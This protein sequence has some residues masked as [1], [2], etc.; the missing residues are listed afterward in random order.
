MQLGLK[1]F[2]GGYSLPERYRAISVRDAR[3]ADQLA[4]DMIGLMEVEIDISDSIML[5]SEDVIDI[6]ELQ[7][8]IQ[9]L[10][11]LRR[12]IITEEPKKAKRQRTKIARTINSFDT[13]DVGNL[14]R[15]RSHED[16]RR[17]LAVWHLPISQNGRVAITTRR[18]S[19]YCEELLLFALRRLSSKNTLDEIS[20]SDFQNCEYSR[21]SR[22]FKYFVEFSARFF[23]S[24]LSN[25]CFKFFEPRFSMHADAIRK[26]CNEKGQ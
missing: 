12:Y 18:H 4:Y 6:W 1:R 26:K 22:G 5:N 8:T 24:K 10:D 9:A 14:F 16:L 23:K 2:R 20:R 13:I 11:T 25:N 21:L 17:L 15:F 3:A 7:D 19:M